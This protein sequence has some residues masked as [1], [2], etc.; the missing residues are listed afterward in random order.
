MWL[1]P[2]SAHKKRPLF[3]DLVINGTN[4]RLV[5]AQSRLENA[6]HPDSKI[7]PE[8]VTALKKEVEKLEKY[9]QALISSKSQLIHIEKDTSHGS[10]DDDSSPK[11]S[12]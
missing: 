12:S 10:D 7:T 4:Q 5:V 6:T 9:L 8:E 1:K 3:I 11:L 2:K